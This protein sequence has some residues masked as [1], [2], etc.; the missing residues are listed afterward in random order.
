[1][2]LTFPLF[3]SAILSKATAHEGI[4]ISGGGPDQ[5]QFSVE[6]FDHKTG[7]SC[8]LPPLPMKRSEHSMNGMTICGGYI[9]TTTIDCINFSSGE[10]VTSHAL[11]EPRYWHCSG[12]TSEGIMLLG[13]DYSGHEKTSETVVPGEFDSQPG[14]SLQYS[15]RR[16]CSISDY[17]TD[18]VIITGGWYAMST[19]TRYDISG[20]LEDLPSLNE[21]RDNHGCAAFSR[22]DSTLALVVSGGSGESGKLSST[23]ILTTSSSAW[24]LTDNLPRKMSGVRIASIAGF[25]YLTGGIDEYGNHRDE[26][27]QL[28]GE[29]WLEVGKMNVVRSSHAVS[30]IKLDD[31][32]D[33]MQFCN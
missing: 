6:I 7:Q 14:F 28:S 9:S 5:S 24:V 19:V 13:G 27:Y 1:M 10:W 23:E 32:N 8:A 25:I 15:T 16:A 2:F 22:E 20:F 29:D 4:L 3:I 12:S 18:T 21:G 30:T 11:A 17:T 33:V 31:A 26:V